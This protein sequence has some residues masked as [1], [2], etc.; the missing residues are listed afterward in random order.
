MGSISRGFRLAKA[1]WGVVRQ[2]HQL[3]VLPVVSFFCSLVVI[4]VFAAGA[5]GIGIPADGESVSPALY[6]LGFVLYVALAFVTIFFNAAIVGTAMKRLNGEDASIKDGLALARQHLGKIFVWA[7][8]TATVGMILRTLQDRAGIVGRIVIGLI[9]VA[10]NV[11]TFFVVPVLL[12][13][14]VG[15]PEAIKR[16]A[17]IFRQRWGEQFIGTATIGLAIFLVAIPVVLVG[18]AVAYAVPVVGVPLLVVAIGVLMAVGAACSGVF[19]A[20]L[21]RFATTGEASSVFSI[22]DLNGSFRP[23]KGFFGKDA[24]GSGTDGR[25]SGLPPAPAQDVPPTRPDAG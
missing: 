18:G 14:P 6:V 20:A 5:F 21:Y 7:L 17:S 25:G 16:S 1:S 11:I 22:E 4:A 13:E 19:N 2:D 3:L 12:Y 23:K 9:G 10:W 24:S 8:I 15:V